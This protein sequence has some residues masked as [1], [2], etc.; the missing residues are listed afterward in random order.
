[1][2]VPVY[3][4]VKYGG[5][6]TM[7]DSS[8]KSMRR[9]AAIAANPLPYIARMVTCSAEGDIAILREDG[10]TDTVW[11]VAGHNPYRFTRLVTDAGTIVKDVHF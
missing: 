11:C 2:A 1:M 5:Y 6:D 3:P 8:P 4:G 10:T 7:D 9:A